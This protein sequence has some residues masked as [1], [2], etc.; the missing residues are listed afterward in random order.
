MQ[1]IMHS[2]SL[3][4]STVGTTRTT[5]TVLALYRGDRPAPEIIRTRVRCH[6]YYPR[7]LFEGSDYFVQELRIVPLLYIRGRRL[8]KKYGILVGI[9]GN[10]KHKYD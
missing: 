6:V 2:L 8:S 4:L 1:Y 3:L 7:L 5:Q 10:S 9:S